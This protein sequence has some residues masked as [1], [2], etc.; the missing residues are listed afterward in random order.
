M[1]NYLF[2]INNNLDIQRIE[3][4]ENHKLNDV[5][6][7]IEANSTNRSVSA[8]SSNTQYTYSCYQ[9][10]IMN[11]QEENVVLNHGDI[12]VTDF[13]LDETY[14]KDWSNSGFSLQVDIVDAFGIIRRLELKNGYSPD[15]KRIPEPIALL[16]LFDILSQLNEFKSWEAFDQNKKYLELQEKYESQKSEIKSLN[17]DIENFKKEAE[18]IQ[19][20]QIK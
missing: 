12:K 8:W 3:K 1:E 11:R 10:K 15:P 16:E 14:S 18:L 19:E 4:L 7:Y 17:K 13:I 5:K 2:I 9:Y 6:Y 20:D